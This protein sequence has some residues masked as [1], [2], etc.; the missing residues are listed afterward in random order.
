[1]NDYFAG[2]RIVSTLSDS[3]VKQIEG[4]GESVTSRVYEIG[5]VLGRFGN[6]IAFVFNHPHYA[7]RETGRYEVQVL[8]MPDFF[9]RLTAENAE[10]V[11][12]ERVLI[13]RNVLERCTVPADK[14]D[15][16]DMES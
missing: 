12:N 3:E 6:E 15:L 11:L 4:A 7:D 8:E 2:L 10:L 14:F 13:P 5:Y 16:V 9:A 1:M